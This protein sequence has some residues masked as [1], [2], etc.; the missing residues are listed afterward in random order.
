MDLT[1]QQPYTTAAAA[2]ASASTAVPFVRSNCM[3][4]FA[5][6]ERLHVHFYCHDVSAHEQRTTS[7][8]PTESHAPPRH[9]DDCLCTCHASVNT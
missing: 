5:Y 4:A 9:D 6:I 1:T 3:M 7:T 8:P 2:A